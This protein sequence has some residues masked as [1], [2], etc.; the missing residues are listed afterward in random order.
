VKG[1]SLIIRYRQVRPDYRPPTTDYFDD[2]GN[3]MN[4]AAV[5]RV[6]ITNY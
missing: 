3:A 1:K 6:L 5:K 4:G 2:S